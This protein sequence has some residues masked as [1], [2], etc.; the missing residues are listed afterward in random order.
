MNSLAEFVNLS[1]YLMIFQ[2]TWT[3]TRGCFHPIAS[4]FCCKICHQ[5]KPR[6]SRRLG[7]KL[8][9]L[10]PSPDNVNLLRGEQHLT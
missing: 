1:L 2:L 4:K 8:H 5:E 7:I 6:E 9:K 3:R 10:S